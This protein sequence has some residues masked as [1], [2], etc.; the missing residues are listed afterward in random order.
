[1]KQT[2]F[3]HDEKLQLQYVGV[4][5]YSTLGGSDGSLSLENDQLT[6]KTEVSQLISYELSKRVDVKQQNGKLL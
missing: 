5:L 1:M 4:I 6:V 2:Y 3:K